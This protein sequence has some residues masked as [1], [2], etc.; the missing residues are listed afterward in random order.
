MSVRDFHAG[1]E[2]CIFYGERSNGD[3]LVHNG[4]VF[5]ENAHD[6]VSIQLGVSKS[7]PLFQMKERLLASMGMT[8]YVL[9]MIIFCHIFI[10]ICLVSSQAFLQD[11]VELE[12]TCLNLF[13]DDFSSL[14]SLL[15]LFFAY[16]LFLSYFAL[17]S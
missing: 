9:K 2:V 14:P 1:E 4:F 13:E 17:K 3:L 16:G 11:V 8:A 6:K 10:R 12:N 15:F 5:E 7:D